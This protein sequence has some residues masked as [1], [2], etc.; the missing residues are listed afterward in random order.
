MV[1]VGGDREAEGGLQPAVCFKPAV[2]I[3]DSCSVL[4][5]GESD[6]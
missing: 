2:Y 1:L 4:F 5:K 6:T 3:R